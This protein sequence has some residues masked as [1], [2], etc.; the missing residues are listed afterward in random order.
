MC[1]SLKS[2]E[3]ENKVALLEERNLDNI[4]MCCHGIRPDPIREDANFK[5]LLNKES[6]TIYV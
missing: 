3:G 5:L 1:I 2:L 6:M 4:S